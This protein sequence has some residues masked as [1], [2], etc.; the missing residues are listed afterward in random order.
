MSLAEASSVRPPARSPDECHHLLHAY[1]CCGDTGARDRLVELHMPLVR[2][3]ARRY[4]NRGEP[5][6]DL[7]QIGSIGLLQA[8]ERFDPDRGRDLAGFAVPTI[9][10]EIR[11]HLR[12][13][14]TVIRIPRRHVESG[15]PRPALALSTTDEADGRLGRALATDA[16]Y[17]SSEDRLMLVAGLRMLT[18]RERRIMHLRFF[19]GLSQGE[20]AEHVGVS[21]VQVSRLIRASLER[22][23]CALSVGES[24][25]A[26]SSGSRTRA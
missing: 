23:R 22:M 25:T 9:A 20:I 17:D 26:S 12:D 21:Q 5:L 18:V 2:A 14:T 15:A 1:R 13:R 6:E 4:V 11:H 24:A 7:V 3:L 19:A 16:P 10:G 8:I